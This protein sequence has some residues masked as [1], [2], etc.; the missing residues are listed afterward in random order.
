MGFPI[1]RISHMVYLPTNLRGSPKNGGTLVCHELRPHELPGITGEPN[2]QLLV[3]APAVGIR[4]ISAAAV[5]QARICG[6]QHPGM[7]GLAQAPEPAAVADATA[8]RV[9]EAAHGTAKLEAL[10]SVLLK[11]GRWER[12]L[13]PS[14]F[15]SCI[16]SRSPNLFHGR[17]CSL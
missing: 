8:G 2:L 1:S 16:F 6:G 11:W 4:L 15:E 3:G 14:P 12:L 7:G 13:F 17:L 9:A 5:S 10:R